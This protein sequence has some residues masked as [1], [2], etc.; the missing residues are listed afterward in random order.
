MTYNRNAGKHNHFT[1]DDVRAKVVEKLFEQMDKGVILLAMNGNFADH[2]FVSWRQ[3]EGLGGH[4]KAG[5]KLSA[6]VFAKTVAKRSTEPLPEGAKPETYYM[7]RW[8]GRM[9]NLEQTEG[10]VGTKFP[11]LAELV[12]TNNSPIERCECIVKNMRNYCRI[13][14]N[15][16]AAYSPQ[17]DRIY[18]PLLSDFKSAE[19]Y[20]KTLFH[21]MMH[22]TEHESRC[23]VIRFRDKRD[24]AYYEL[25]AEIGAAILCSYAG[26][27]FDIEHSAAYIEGW[28]SKINADRQLIM[29]A[30]REAMAGVEYI[31]RLDEE[32]EEDT[33]TTE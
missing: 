8:Y 2:R 26:I 17:F 23:N 13:E 27:P 33:D 12:G 31:L 25:R 30:S 5:S 3:M 9:V 28:R 6:V 10:L 4:V 18:M 32:S 7:L 1:N 14:F 15:P 20:Y 24:Y 16:Q 11:T 22:S 29:T 19:A 21:E